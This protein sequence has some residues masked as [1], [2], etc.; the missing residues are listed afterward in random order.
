MSVE[1]T[2]KPTPKR[3]K[4]ARKRGQVPRS[5]DLTAV[6][7]F[8]SSVCLLLW[9]W[10]KILYEITDSISWFLIAAVTAENRPEKCAI[11]IMSL[12]KIVM[13]SLPIWL[14]VWVSALLIN[15]FQIGFLLIKIRSDLKRINPIQGLK[16]IF[17]SARFVEL[18]KNIVKFIMVAA[19][20][21][22]VVKQFF[23]DIVRS[24]YGE[25]SQVVT[26]LFYVC[27]RFAVY[28]GVVFV[29]IGI[30]DFLYQK[31]KWQKDLMMSRDEIKQE[32]KE[33]EGDPL[34]K[35][36]RRQMQFEISQYDMDQ[37][38]R[39][40]KVVVVN[41]SHLTVALGYDPDSGLAPQIA[42]KGVC[43][44]GERI[45]R[46]AREADI[47]IIKNIPVARALYRVDIGAE[48]P[49][50]LFEAVAEILLFLDEVSQKEHY[51]TF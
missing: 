5:N 4:E 16:G 42:A 38:V 49:E 18:V 15:Y 36:Y 14:L 34:Y 40:S 37:R 41:P 26:V 10:D 7:T 21:F 30:F 8:I 33:M 48:I 28:A 3:I 39:E 44:T 13:W 22:Y 35:N 23:S 25:P 17:S 12:K 50:N 9:Q 45:R 24:L 6:A 11:L 27:I 51:S 29:I 43:E 1:K 19:L 31:H 2:E 32:H 20:G 46:I 47:P